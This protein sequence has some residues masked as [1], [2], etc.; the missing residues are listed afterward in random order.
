MPLVHCCGEFVSNVHFYHTSKAHI[1]CIVI[2]ALRIKCIL[3]FDICTYIHKGWYISFGHTVWILCMYDKF[4]ET[5]SVRNSSTNTVMIL[6]IRK[7]GPGNSITEPPHHKTNKM[8]CA[9]SEDSDQ[10]GHP[11]SLIRVFPVRMKKAQVL[12]YPLSAQRKF[13]SDWADAQADLSLLWEHNH[14]VGFVM[15]RLICPDQI[16]PGKQYEPTTRLLLKDYIVCHSAFVSL[17]RI[18]Q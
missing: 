3:N 2:N 17:R 4:S 14:F 12:S 11:P 8:A 6:S 18:T 15:R 7:T 9:P 5:E 13:W 10:P 16:A 1:D